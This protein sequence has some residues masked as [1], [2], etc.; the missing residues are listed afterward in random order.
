MLSRWARFM[1]AFAT[2]LA[3]WVIATPARATAP[4]CDPHGAT[5][6]APA[7]TLQQPET[8]IDIG[9]PDD[10][11]VV[12]ALTTAVDDGR[13]PEPSPPSAARE[14][15][16][17]SAVPVVAFSA[18]SALRETGSAVGSERAGAR[19]RVDRPPRGV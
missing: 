10:C 5:G 14:P 19:A 7:P 18:C 2:A 15:A 16:V 4:L 11:D 13:A 1:V 8:S 3:V 12:L 9:A 6:I 17:P